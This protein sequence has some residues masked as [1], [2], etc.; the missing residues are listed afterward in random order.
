[1]RFNLHMLTLSTLA[2]VSGLLWLYY[3]EYQQKNDAYQTLSQRYKQQQTITDN[4]FQTIRII[5][6]ISRINNENRKR[7][8]VDAAQIQAVI[9]TAVVGNDCARRAAPDRAVV[10]LQQH[11]NRIRSGTVDADSDAFAR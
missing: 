3:G 2:A 7:S 5:N 4:A 8:T 10:R 11:A 1:M 6:D 9:N